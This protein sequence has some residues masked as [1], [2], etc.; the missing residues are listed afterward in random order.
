MNA[1]TKAPGSLLRPFFDDFFELDTFLNRTPFDRTGFK[2]PAVNIAE[3]DKDFVVEMAVPGLKKEDI[4]VKVEDNVMYISAEKKEEKEEKDKNYTRKE[5][6]YNSFS[7]SFQLPENVRDEM[8]SAA[9]EDG[10][11]R[12]TMPKV[13]EEV[14]PVKEIKVG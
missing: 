10:V 4:H 11:L 14:K 5:Y 12:L 7:R 3:T 2:F 6:N 13:K 9:Y 8:I 1:L